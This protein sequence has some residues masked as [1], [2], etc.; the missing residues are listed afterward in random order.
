MV[1][2]FLEHSY[3]FMMPVPYLFIYLFVFMVIQPQPHNLS[4]GQNSQLLAA[5]LI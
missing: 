1:R 4:V 5:L 2:N 3:K